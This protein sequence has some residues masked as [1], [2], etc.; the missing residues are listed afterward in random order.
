MIG[1]FEIF[2]NRS[3]GEKEKIFAREYGIASADRQNDCGKGLPPHL[4]IGVGVYPQRP[5]DTEIDWE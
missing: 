2:F 3:F 1:Y 4:C 5:V